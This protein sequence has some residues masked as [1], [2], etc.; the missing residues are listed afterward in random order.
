MARRKTKIRNIPKPTPRSVPDRHRLP[1]VELVKRVEPVVRPRPTRPRPDLKP[2]ED[3]RTIPRDHKNTPFRTT[4]GRIARVETRP[5][6]QVSNPRL[7]AQ[8][9]TYFQ[10]PERVLVC[11]RR[12]ARKRVLFALRKVGKGKRVTRERTYSDKSFV[13]CK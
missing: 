4:S 3:L 5:Q 10:D 8:V 13:R 12:D 11:I 7:P 6:G 2:I 1:P 9:H